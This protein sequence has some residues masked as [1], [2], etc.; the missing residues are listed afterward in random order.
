MP[1]KILWWLAAA[2]IVANLSL[3]SVLGTETDIW[4]HLAAGK[5]FWQHGLELTDPYSFTEPNHPWVRI[6]W[7]FQALIF[8]IFNWG[9]LPALLVLRAASLLGATGLLFFGLRRRS[10]AEAWLLVM[11]TAWIWA[12]SVS[13]RP[14]TASLFFNTLWVVLLEEARHGKRRALWALPPVMWLWFNVHVAALAGILLLGLYMVG[15]CLESRAIGWAWVRSLVFSFLATF[16]NPQ[17]WKLVYYPLHFLLVKSPW[18]DIILEVQPPH[19][20]TPGTWQA[21][22]LLGLAG[23]GSLL[24][25]RQ[26]ERQL[27]PLLVTLTCGFLMNGV[28]RH[29]YQLCVALVPFAALRLPRPARWLT[30]AAAAWLALH[31]LTALVCLR[32]PLSAL[33][34]RESFSERLVA[35][36]SQGPDGLRV[37]T[38]MNGAGYFMYHF[39]G[40]QKIFIDSRTDQVYLQPNFLNDYYTIWLGRPGALGLLDHYQVQAVVNNR[41]T[42]DGSPLFEQLKQS[43]VWTCVSSDMIGEFYVRNA[44]ADRFH[45]PPM[46]SFLS[47]YIS[48][49]E[50]ARQNQLDQAEASWR[51]SL[52][53]YPQFANDYQ[54]LARVLAYQGKRS[55]ARRALARAEFY[56]SQLVGLNEDWAKLGVTWPAWVR[57][58]FLPFW[59]L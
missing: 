35:L 38:D 12:Q 48:G 33:A 49:V 14:A 8:P 19:W 16:L 40:R 31:A 26:K 30:G 52:Q 7:L 43:G 56:H 54:W 34:R 51:R 42:S 20:D 21:R 53:D 28:V 2:L 22:L 5:R 23:M 4:W 50:Q 15:N 32:L 1:L 27:T 59:A 10:P 58:F 36:A 13:L 25:L 44:L 6:D 9:G 39:D 18:R 29:Q 55:E 3:G 57:R 24:A 11:L 37:F 47:D 17:G 45:E 41:A 46:P